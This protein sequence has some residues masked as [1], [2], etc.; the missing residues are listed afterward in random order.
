MLNADC[1]TDLK[2]ITYDRITH[3]FAALYAGEYIGS[4]PTYL[5]A[6]IA[7]DHFA[8]DLAAL[9]YDPPTEPDPTPPPWSCLA[10]ETNE[11]AIQAC[12]V[13]RAALF[14]PACECGAQPTMFVID[15]PHQRLVCT[16]C[17][18][19]AMPDIRSQY[20]RVGSIADQAQL[21]TWGS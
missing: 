6:E 15:G 9:A 10:C 20:A 3:D 17:C 21:A 12:P 2:A 16:D 7:L 1:I 18:I 4:Y 8:T 19:A 11:H 5:A 14:A 13:I